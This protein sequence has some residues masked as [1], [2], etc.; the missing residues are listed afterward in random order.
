MESA[1]PASPAAGDRLTGRGNPVERLSR[2]A[3]CC[4]VASVPGTTVRNVLRPSTKRPCPISNRD[5]FG[6]TETSGTGSPSTREMP[7]AR[8]RKN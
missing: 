6:M 8:H 4:P 2:L 5:G 3:S 1:L 7:I